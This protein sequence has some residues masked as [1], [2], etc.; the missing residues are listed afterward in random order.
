MR[1]FK[2]VDLG[3]IDYSE[4]LKE[5]LRL[6]DEVIA[7]PAKKFLILCSHPPVVT[8]GRASK[9]EDLQGWQG[10]TLEVSRGGKATYH[11]PSQLVVYPIFHLENRDLHAYLQWLEQKVVDFLKLSDVASSGGFSL[12]RDDKD[13]IRTGVW[14]KD[15]KI[16]SIGIAVKKWVCYHGVA[17]N[18][19]KD[20]S[21]FQGISPCG[22]TAQT[23]VSLEEVQGK[24]PAK[25]QVKKHLLRVFACE[26]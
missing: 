2:V 19:L 11:G 15:R 24:P 4:A 17:I 3:L 23:M 21:A 25:E 10:S 1:S 7:D 26:S 5:Q 12:D 8:L 16:A 14:I 9:P 20:P 18:I 6:V 22:F 13:G